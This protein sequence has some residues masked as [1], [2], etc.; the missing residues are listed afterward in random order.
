MA[1]KET[2]R[3]RGVFER[4]PGSGVWWINYYEGGKQHREKVGPKQ[5]AIDLYKI[6]KAAILAGRKLPD[7]KTGKVTLSALIDDVLEYAKTHASRAR[8]YE[9]KAEIVR[10]ALGSRIASSITPQDLNAWLSKHCKTP[11]TFNR[12]KAFLSL[13]W[14]QAMI[15]QKADSNPARLV[16]QRKEPAGRLRFLSYDEYGKLFKVIERRCPEHLAEFIVSVHT[17]MRLAEQYTTTWSQVSF[18]RKSIELSK[19]KNG[20]RRTVHLNAHALSAIQ[21]AQLPGKK[22]NDV[23]FPSAEK[24]FS[25]RAWFD[26]CLE[27]AEIHEYVWHSN[28]HT[29]CSWL[30]M[31][32]ASTREIMIAAGHKTF[33]MAARYSH[34]SPTHNQGVVDR[35]SAAL[36]NA[37]G[38]A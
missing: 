33:T 8:D 17:G 29:F 19:T 13:V 7:L 18:E 5:G 31:N 24:E 11:A 36:Q 14:K 26:P 4:P 12:Y 9:S 38:T 34:L 21:S 27:E 1:K 10:E 32:G 25:T 22:A 2:K 16:R 6:R 3:V 30:A 35:I 20:S 28:R 15:N 37:A 23:V